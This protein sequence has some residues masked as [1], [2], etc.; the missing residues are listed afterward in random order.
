VRRGSLYRGHR[1]ANSGQLA[2]A[3]AAAD[4]AGAVFYGGRRDRRGLEALRIE[5]DK[6]AGAFAG[7]GCREAGFCE[8]QVKNAALARGHRRER[9]WEAGS[10]DLLD[11]HLGHKVEFAVA[12]GLEAVG[13]EGDS[14]MFL[15]L[16]TEDLGGDVFDGVKEFTVAGQ[17][18][19]SIGAGEF[20]CDFGG[21]IG[22]GGGFG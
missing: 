15:G 14:V 17:E 2:A 18:E 8:G 6:A 1:T 9:E 19:G 16:E 4:G 3:K 22:R 20:D 12:G 11:G 7:R 5:D 10:A 21:G 13:V